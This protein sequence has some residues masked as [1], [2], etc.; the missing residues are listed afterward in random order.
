MKAMSEQ[1]STTSSLPAPKHCKES[2]VFKTGRVF[3]NDVNNHQTLFGGTY[4][5][6]E[7]A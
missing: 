5:F 6:L 2:R 7:R 4:D 1:Q 3:P